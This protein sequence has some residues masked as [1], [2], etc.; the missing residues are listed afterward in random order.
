MTRVPTETIYACADGTPFPVVWENPA[1]AALTYRWNQDHLPLPFPPLALAIERLR[2]PGRLRAHDE[3]GVPVPVQ[4]R[5]VVLPHGFQY[6]RLTPLTPEDAAEM[7]EA[8]DRIV[9][10]CGDVRAVWDT[11]GLPRIQAACAQLQAADDTTAI[12]SLADTF[13]YGHAQSFVPMPAVTLALSRLTAFLAEV[14]GPEA[15]RLAFELGQGYA[16]G[17]L[18]VDQALWELARLV[19]QSPRTRAALLSAAPDEALDAVRRAG[20]AAFLAALDA[21]LDQYGERAGGWD[22]TSPTWRERPATPLALVRGMVERPSTSATAATAEA[23]Q[24]REALIVETEARLPDEVGRERFRALLAPMEH[25]VYVREGRALW[26]LTVT[27]SLRGALLRH[28]ARLVRAGSIRSAEDVY[29]L[30]PDEVGG[31]TGQT[32][33]DP[34]VQE[35]RRAWSAWAGMVAPPTIGAGAAPLRA[36][37]ESTPAAPPATVLR[38]VGASRG[39]VTAR[40]RLITDPADADTLAAGEVL[41]CIMTTPEWTP[42]F[43]VAGAIVTDSGGMLSHPSIAAREYGIPAVVG[44]RGATTAIPDGALITVDGTSGVVRLE[45]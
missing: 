38:G 28:G 31:G 34:L 25:Y 18:A 45:D 36:A 41:L 26:Q 30:M 10:A 37:V 4:F 5:T 27:G 44:V 6:V 39:T 33:L 43:G 20:D 19:E 13:G 40:A 14:M 7:S 8:C 24:R 11:W 12:A 21:L 42:L 2:E 29:F 1:E 32:D 17:T 35:R 16:N 15:E 23:A 3:A 9:E 22:L